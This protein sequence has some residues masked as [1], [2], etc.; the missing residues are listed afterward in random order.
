VKGLCCSRHWKDGNALLA[1]L[2]FLSLS[3]SLAPQFLILVVRRKRARIH[4]FTLSLSIATELRWE[5]V[6]T[7]F[8]RRRL[9]M[10]ISQCGLV[11]VSARLV[12]SLFQQHLATWLF[13]FASPAGFAFL[14][15][16]TVSR[17]G[18]ICIRQAY[19]RHALPPLSSPL[20][21]TCR[22]H[23]VPRLYTP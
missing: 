20:T 4:L 8:S 12:I 16:G 17:A 18:C 6:L 11:S 1:L 19:T 15:F 21:S 2:S 23:A 10:R 9:Q 22:L 14:V 7:S 13:N 3:P 5:A